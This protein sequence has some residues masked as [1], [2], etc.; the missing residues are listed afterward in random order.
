MT[1]ASSGV[2]SFS[3]LRTEYTGGSGAAGAAVTGISIT[4]NNSGNVYGATA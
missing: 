2:V 4:I 1:I 3:D